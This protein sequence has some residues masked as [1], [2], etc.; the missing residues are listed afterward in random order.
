[1]AEA[2]GDALPPALAARIGPLR[3]LRKRLAATCLF[4]VITMVILGLQVFARFT[5][6]TTIVLVAVAAMC[7]WRVYRNRVAYGWM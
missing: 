2:T 4:L 1:M 7:A 3:V 6:P 5:P